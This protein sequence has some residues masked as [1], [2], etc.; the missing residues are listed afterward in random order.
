MAQLVDAFLPHTDLSAVAVYLHDADRMR[1]GLVATDMQRAAR[2]PDDGCLMAARR[3]VVGILRM[4]QRLRFMDMSEGEIVVAMAHRSRV[5]RLQCAD[6]E[7]MPCRV[8]ARHGLVGHH[9]DGQLLRVLLCH[10]VEDSL[11]DG[12]AVARHIRKG[13][14]ISAVKTHHERLLPAVHSVKTVDGWRRTHQMGIG[15]LPHGA[16]GLDSR[17]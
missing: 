7:M 16:V 13:H 1:I 9:H 6:V 11:H 10:I 5:E 3:P 14:D 15:Q 4:A 2:I 17:G 12:A 8:E